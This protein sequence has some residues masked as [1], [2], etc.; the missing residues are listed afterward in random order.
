MVSEKVIVTTEAGLHFRPADKLSVEALK[1]EC[2]VHFKAG[3]TTG[4]LK[5]FL[6]ILAAGVKQNSEIEII[7]DGVDEVEALQNI[8]QLIRTGL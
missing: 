8:I 3:D 2:A 1:Y 5:S 6:G 4:S 7:C